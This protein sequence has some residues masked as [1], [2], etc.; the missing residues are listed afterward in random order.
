MLIL[1]QPRQRSHLPG[2][3]KLEHRIGQTGKS[4]IAEAVPQNDR[5]R[6]QLTPTEIVTKTKTKIETETKQSEGRVKKKL[7][8]LLI[9]ALETGGKGTSNAKKYGHKQS[10]KNDNNTY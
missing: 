9:P 5:P 2:P 1:P 4:R 8:L 3:K 10:E 7:L 6:S